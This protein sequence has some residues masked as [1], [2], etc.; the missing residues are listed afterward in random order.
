ML[1]L[2][3]LYK[4]RLKNND[5]MK[6]YF[7]IIA[8]MAIMF[9]VSCGPSVKDLE[10][11]GIADSIRIADSICLSQ[12]ETTQMITDSIAKAKIKGFMTRSLTP[13]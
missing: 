10:N 5:I 3:R 6:K 4:Y 7:G 12:P 2:T 13:Q 9:I 1:K 8:I 11:K